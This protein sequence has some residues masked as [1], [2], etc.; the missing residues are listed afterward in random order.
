MNID[1][2][3]VSAKI[4]GVRKKQII[5]KT[6]TNEFLLINKPAMLKNDKIF[7]QVMFDLLRNELW[8]PV[9]KK[10]KKLMR[11]DWLDDSAE[12]LAF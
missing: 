11:Y 9:N 8:I 10:L 12:N 3:I 1:L 4:V 2:N 5:C 7:T 6:E